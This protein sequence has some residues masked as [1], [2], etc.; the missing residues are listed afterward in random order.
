M[1]GTKLI[2]NK[3]NIRSA[4]I[5]INN[6][7]SIAAT[8]LTKPS[9]GHYIFDKLHKNVIAL[10]KKHLGM[11]I[12]IKWVPGHKGVEGNE[13]ADEEAKKGITMGSSDKRKLPNFLRKMLPQSKSVAKC[14]H[15]EKLK[16]RAQKGWQSSERYDRM[17]KT[18]PTTPSHKY[19][20]LI[21]TLPRKLASILSQL[22]TGHTPLA[23]H[24]H[25]I[26]KMNSPICPACQQSEETVQHF[27]LHCLAHQA[28]RQTL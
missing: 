10:Q 22:R 26:G 6:R 3:W 18:D 25:R 4:F 11:K 16:R 1:L 9:P 17:K 15:N 13:R 19:I 20:D 7:A 12:K 28:A 14:T 24:L 21:T 5:Y 8:Q 27:M 2:S 23:K